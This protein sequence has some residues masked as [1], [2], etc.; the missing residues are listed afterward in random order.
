MKKINESKDWFFEKINT[1]DKP[2]ARLINNQREKIQ[3]TNIKNEREGAS[4]Q[5]LQTLKGEEGSIINNLI[6]YIWQLT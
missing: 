4:L 2:L 6:E 1:T 5:I 3:I